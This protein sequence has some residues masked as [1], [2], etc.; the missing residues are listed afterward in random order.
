MVLS[1]DTSRRAGGVR[2]S[3]HVKKEKKIFLFI[4]FVLFGV[5]KQNVLNWAS[6]GLCEMTNS[7]NIYFLMLAQNIFFMLDLL[8]VSFVYK[9]LELMLY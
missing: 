1:P 2:K 8:Q 4:L 6:I 9:A 5:V 3:I 7:N